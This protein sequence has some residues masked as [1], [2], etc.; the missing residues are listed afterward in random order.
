LSTVGRDSPA[1]DIRSPD[2]IMAVVQAD[3]SASSSP[4][5]YT[6]IAMADICSSA[7]MSSV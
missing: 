3:S 7:T 1:K 5:K 4:W 2:L 6:A